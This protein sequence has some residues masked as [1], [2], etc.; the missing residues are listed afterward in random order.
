VAHH[1]DRRLRPDRLIGHGSQDIAASR[2]VG[3]EQPIGARLFRI[4]DAVRGA[5]PLFGQK[6]RFRLGLRLGG[7]ERVGQSHAM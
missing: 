7:L 4:L 5:L 2:H 3:L 6:K 1:V